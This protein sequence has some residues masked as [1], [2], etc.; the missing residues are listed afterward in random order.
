MP[1]PNQMAAKDS[2]D[3]PVAI[4]HSLADARSV[5]RTAGRLRRRVYIASAEAAG[6]FAGPLWF[7]GLAA[8]AAEE[9][10]A[11]LAGALLDCGPY[12][13]PV[14]EALTLGLPLIRFT[15]P[16]PAAG[17]LRAQAEACGARLVVGDLKAFDCR[18]SAN[19]EQDLEAWLAAAE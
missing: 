18:S 14:M 11:S 2:L 16:A 7:Q 15:G 4:V 19:L 6:A 12:A 8:A 1:A 17:K 9:A 13:G 3:A 5:L 10:G